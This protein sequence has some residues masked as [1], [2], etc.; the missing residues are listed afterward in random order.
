MDTEWLD[1]SQDTREMNSGL[2]HPV[3]RVTEEISVNFSDLDF[4]S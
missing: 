4:R 1:I 3:S 2:I